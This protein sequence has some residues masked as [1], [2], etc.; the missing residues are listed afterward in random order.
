MLILAIDTSTRSRSL[1]LMRDNHILAE[2]SDTEQSPYSERLFRDLRSL[3]SRHPFQMGDIDVYAVAA[4]PGSFTGLRVSLTAA[5][6]WSEVYGKPIA[7]V[8]ALEA[9]AA[10]TEL[11]PRVIGA[12][13]DAKRGQ[14]FGA[15]Y[16]PNSEGRF[17]L[18]GEELLIPAG[19][20]LAHLKAISGVIQPVLVSPS[21][22]AIPLEL[23]AQVFPGGRVEK[24]SSALA[25]F[26]GRLGFERAV[27]GDLVDSLTLDA[28]YIRRSDAEVNRKSA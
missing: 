16:S 27:R 19:E 8:S 17:K 15:A 14:V 3:Q 25:P 12:Y 13:F 26:I 28:N 9:I 24:V 5:K 18:I 4:G 1:A 23:I 20:F 2:V 10:Q 6:G 21:A 22:E 11:R 7:A